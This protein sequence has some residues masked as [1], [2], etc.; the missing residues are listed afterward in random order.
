M[1]NEICAHS[2]AFTKLIATF[3]HCVKQACRDLANLKILFD[4]R[5]Y[6][7]TYCA[8][9]FTGFMY[10]R[11]RKISGD[12]CSGGSEWIFQPRQQTCP[13]QGLFDFHFLFTLTLYIWHCCLQ[14]FTL[15]NAL[16]D[17]T[18]QCETSWSMKG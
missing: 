2:F 12:K 8:C 6:I 1:R 15:A 7:S 11:Y 5:L 4:K 3:A 9:G 17:F 13:F 18:R 14:H 10:I 16:D